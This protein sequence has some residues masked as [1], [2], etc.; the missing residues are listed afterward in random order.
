MSLQS[1]CLDSLGL[2]HSPWTI[3]RMEKSATPAAELT[4]QLAS[5]LRLRIQAPTLLNY[6]SGSLV[7]SGVLEQRSAILQIVF[8]ELAMRAR[9]AA[10]R[11]RSNL[12]HASFA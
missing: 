1:L 10:T 3:Q 9:F 2:R 11:C 6:L 5:R 4:I 12:C 7:V 8:A